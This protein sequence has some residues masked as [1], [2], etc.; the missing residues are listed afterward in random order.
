MSRD[1]NEAERIV[2]VWRQTTLTFVRQN[3]DHHTKHVHS[4]HIRTLNRIRAY[5]YISL[6]CKGYTCI[7]KSN[8]SPDNRTD[9]ANKSEIPQCTVIQ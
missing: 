8:Q 1:V 4:I 7:F 5:V 6:D 2:V 3:S 9:V